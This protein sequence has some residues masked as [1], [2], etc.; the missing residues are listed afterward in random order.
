VCR[1]P[2]SGRRCAARLI[3]SVLGSLLL[4]AATGSARLPQSAPQPQ[5]EQPP[6]RSGVQLVE[7][8]VRVFDRDG[9]FVLDLKPEDFEMLENGAPQQIRSLYLI[10]GRR[11]A[12]AVAPH[13]AVEGSTATPGPPAAPAR[14]TW[15]FVFDVN[16]LTPGSGFDRARKA[17][18]EFLAARFN[19]GDLGGIVA[20][21]RMVNNKLTSVREELVAAARSVKPTADARNRQIELT[22][23][24]PRLRDEWE[25]I[26]ISNNDGE[27]LKRAVIRACSEESDSCQRA[28]LEVREKARRLHTE[29]ERATAETLTALNALASGLARVPG[30][31]AIVFLSDGFV[32]ERMET[33]LRQVVGQT[34]RAG[35]RVYAI[36][37]R[38]LNRGGGGGIIDEPTVTD[39]AGGPAAFDMIADGANSLAVDTGGLMIRNENNIGRALDRIAGDANTYYVVAYQSADTVFDG[40][41][42][43]IEVRVNRPGVR[44]RARKGYLALEPSRLLVPQS[45]TTPSQPKDADEIPAGALAAAAPLPSAEGVGTSVPVPRLR[46]AA[47]RVEALRD[48]ET[49]GVRLAPTAASQRAHEG[50]A[51]YA[52]G[53]VEGARDALADA[54]AADAP[55]W[56]FFA[57][58]LSEFALQNFQ[59][60][61]DAWTHVR[62]RAPDLKEVYFDLADAHLQMSDTTRA[63]A[64]LRDGEKRWPSEPEF[65]NAIGVIHVR[66]GA[67]DEGIAAFS[68]ATELAPDEPLGY[69]NLARAYEMRYVRSHRYLASQRRWVS[70]E[71]DRRKATEC[72]QRYLKI[73]GPYQQ[74]ATEALHRLE[75][76]R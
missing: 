40:T 16:H 24:W 10:D 3:A 55:V 67:L 9:R 26:Q 6:F 1:H 71:S 2:D 62:Q 33:S 49:A 12:A 27:A 69:F 32:T 8:D 22:R 60:A 52:K 57:L 21:T 14:Q 74:A 70:S 50:W 45:V 76:V 5:K 35:A 64:V 58:G 29:I 31:K 56:V 54:A 72:Y 17:V 73:G 38:G 43:P 4:A 34:A 51:M 61:L 59:G 42:R 41:F 25:A 20:G 46:D 39:S 68:R 44:V 36:D 18:E 15:I 19:E 47:E 30:P 13:R 65:Q 11:P 37:V 63:L 48:R 23:Q 66:R 53:D 28:E 75:W 7:V